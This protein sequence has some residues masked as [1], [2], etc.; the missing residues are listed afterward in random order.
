MIKINNISKCYAGKEVLSNLTINL[1]A[2]KIYGLLGKNG[3]GKTTLLK[4]ITGI[5]KPDS[6]EINIDGYTLKENPILYKK[7]YGYVADQYDIF[8]NLTGAEYLSFI[9]DMYD[10]SINK[11]VK[12]IEDLTKRLGL[13]QALGDRISTYSK[14][15]KQK[16][17]II[18]ELIHEPK[19]LILDE[20]LNG[21]DP[22]SIYE[23]KNI[24]KNMSK[25]GGI[26]IFS[27]HLIEI[28]ENLSDEI[29]ILSDKKVAYNSSFDKKQFEGY[30]L[31]E[32]F[33]EITRRTLGNDIK[34][35]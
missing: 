3:V 8:L 23:V 34:Q 10:V 1:E 33:L 6:G 32:I 27:T 16:L 22:E 35:K 31:E 4:V 11:R 9:L 14:G 17:L 19:I 7:S 25:L 20:P 30:S 29:I 26:V 2:G 5:L 15:M 21:L 28:A 12:N 24:L 18:G 13:V